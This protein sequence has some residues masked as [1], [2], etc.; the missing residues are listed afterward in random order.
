MAGYLEEEM[1]LRKSKRA[2]DYIIVTFKKGTGQRRIR[3][4][5]GGLDCRISKDLSPTG[6][7]ITL[8]PEGKTAE[9]MVSAFQKVPQVLGA[10]IN[11]AAHYPS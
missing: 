10:I 6:A 8:I 3:E 11:E 9:E 4:I 1:S 2:E 7:I 5:V